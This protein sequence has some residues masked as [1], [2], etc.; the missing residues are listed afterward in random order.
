[1]A[2]RI[3]GEGAIAAEQILESNA[4]RA[5]DGVGVEWM[6]GVEVRDLE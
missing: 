6:G 5:G 1:M 4:V 3:D 2:Y